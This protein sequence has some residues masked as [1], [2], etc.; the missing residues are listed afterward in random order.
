MA[1]ENTFNQ[2]P[3][4]DL[5]KL[6]VGSTHEM[7]RLENE[8]KTHG[9]CF[10][11]LP[12]DNDQLGKRIDDA[13]SELDRFFTLSEQEKSDFKS[14][15]AFGYSRIDH[16]EGIK[17]LV[18]QFGSTQQHP[19]LTTQ[20]EQ[21]LQALAVLLRNFTDFLQ[22][23]IYKMPTMVNSPVRNTVS[24]SPLTMLDI[25]NYFNE[26]TG[27]KKVPEVGLNTHEVNCV[28]H[29]DPGLFSLSILSTCDG[30]QLKDHISE[31]WIDGPVNTRPDERYIAA[32][33]LGE[34]ASLLT[35]NH[36][37][38]GIHRVIYPRTSHQSRLTIWQEVCTIKQIEPL[39]TVS[40]DASIYQNGTIVEL[41]NQ[42]E[43]EPME[44]SSDGQSY[45]RLMKKV[46][47][48]RGISMSKSGHH[49]VRPASKTRTNNDSNSSNVATNRV[50]YLPE[51]ASVTMTNQPNSIPMP[52]KQGGEPVNQFMK[53]IEADRGLS[54]SKSGVEHLEIRFPMNLNQQ[55]QV[56]KKK[57][58]LFGNFFK[59]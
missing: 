50:N 21:T 28:P 34:A 23:I 7:N 13:R 20:V 33:W 10:I 41:A 35:Q 2:H 24:L 40:N 49:Y 12:N 36:F 8:F 54:M 14:S 47:K 31:K 1:T 16:K 59:K 29:F 48:E 51:G 22:S 38:P 37:K 56:P 11:R 19:Q 9:W 5:Q 6:L 17:V 26:R 53:R 57:S 52:V 27:P 32:V 44:I 55:Q 30:L 43:S 4:V 3:L 46:E 39:I 25:V 18:D 58:S 42:P 15:T 45:N